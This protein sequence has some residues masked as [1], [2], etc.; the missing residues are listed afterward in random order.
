M[1]LS[2]KILMRKIKKR[3]KNKLKLIHMKEND[4]LIQNSEGMYLFSNNYQYQN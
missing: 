1:S 2:E 4:Q 3:E